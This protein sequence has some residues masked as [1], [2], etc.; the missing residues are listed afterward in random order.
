MNRRDP[1]DNQGRDR[2]SGSN[3]RAAC[4]FSTSAINKAEIARRRA[5][6]NMVQDVIG[7]AIGG[8]S[9][10]AVFEGDRSFDIV[11]RLPEDIRGDV[12][13]LDLPVSLPLAGP[14]AHRAAGRTGILQNQ[15]GQIRSAR[16]ASDELS[17]PRTYG[18]AT[19][20]PSY[21]ARA[22][23]KLASPCH[24]ATGCRGAASLI[25][26]QHGRNCPL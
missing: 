14:R 6:L 18:I 10:G 15:R 26:P 5:D 23:S 21:D 17:L 7:T 11:V 9:T 16:T 22:R 13:A 3:R 25:S 12:D 1:E 2:C 20:H 24:P 4:R 8:R 19:S